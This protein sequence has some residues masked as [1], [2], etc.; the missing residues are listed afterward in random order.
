MTMMMEI[1]MAT[2]GRLMKNL[3]ISIQSVDGSG[4]N[5]VFVLSGS[6]DFRSQQVCALSGRRTAEFAAAVR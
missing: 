4:V 6:A 1:T 3:D 5:F 2:M